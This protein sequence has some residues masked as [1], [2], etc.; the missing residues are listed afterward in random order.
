MRTV[1]ITLA[2]IACLATAA[3]SQAQEANP[4]RPAYL[5]S[6]YSQAAAVKQ[7]TIA[8]KAGRV[9]S[10]VD[11]PADVIVSLHLLKGEYNTEQIAKG[12][13]NLSGD[14]A[15]RTLPRAE[16]VG[17]PM[18]AQMERAPFKLDLRDAVVAVQLK[19]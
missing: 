6:W 4:V 1:T 16:M 8:D 17:G 19:R 9:L 12:D 5:M 3:F 13:V 2:S 15:V 11:V 18:W 7:V 10:V 14:I